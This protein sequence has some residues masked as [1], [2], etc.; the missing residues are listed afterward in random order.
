MSLHWYWSQEVKLL[1]RDVEYDIEYVFI[2]RL[3][4][5]PEAE[6]FAR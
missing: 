1:P 6:S 3:V 2:L 4:L 5:E